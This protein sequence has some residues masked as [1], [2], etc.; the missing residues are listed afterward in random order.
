MLEGKTPLLPPLER[1]KQPCCMLRTAQLRS[2]GVLIEHIPIGPTVVQGKGIDGDNQSGNI[3][4]ASSS[5][6]PQKVPNE[7]K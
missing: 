5:P 6:S 3:Q 2:G 4:A 1:Q 7:G